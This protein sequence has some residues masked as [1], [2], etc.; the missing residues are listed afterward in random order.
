MAEE[1][2]RLLNALIHSM[3]LGVQH[4]VPVKAAAKT[5]AG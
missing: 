4:P 1:L 3:K 2:A 5:Q